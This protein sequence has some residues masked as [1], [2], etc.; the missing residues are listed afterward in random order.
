MFF[1]MFLLSGSLLSVTA[2]A[3]QGFSTDR[4]ARQQLDY[5][6]IFFSKRQGRAIKK[7]Y[8]LRDLAIN[9]QE[10]WLL[11]KRYL[12]YF[13]LRSHRLRKFDF[14]Q[15][16]ASNDRLFLAREGERVYLASSQLVF[17]LGERPRIDYLGNN[18]R[19]IKKFFAFIADR[20]NFIWITA[21]GAEILDRQDNSWS[22]F[23]Y[24]LTANDRVV[25]GPQRQVMWLKRGK[26]LS[27][28]NRD[29][30][31]K[32]ILTATDLDLQAGNDSLYVKRTKTVLRYSYDG[33]LLQVIPI[34]TRRQLTAMHVGDSGH[35][36]LFSDGLFE[37]YNLSKKLLLYT[38]LDLQY[39]NKKAIGSFD[40]SASSFAFLDNGQGRVFVLTKTEG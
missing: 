6:E 5:R 28:I 36:Y 29:Q 22:S 18:K 30:T 4:L 38:Q 11:G 24:P 16:I 3:G 26:K 9:S 10:L 34:K 33:Q 39:F 19:R 35:G 21:N 27:I 32:Q 7:D 40:L 15:T 13:N 20:Q 1:L 23:R 37:Y 25:L 12:W 2:R 17:D 14:S 8:P 31:T